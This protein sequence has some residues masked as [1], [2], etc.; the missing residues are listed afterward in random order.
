MGNWAALN[1]YKPNQLWSMQIKGTWPVELQESPKSALW[2]TEPSMMNNCKQRRDKHIKI[3]AWWHSVTHVYRLCQAWFH[4]SS[5][6]TLR[7]HANVPFPF[8]G[9]KRIMIICVFWFQKEVK[10]Y[11]LWLQ[12]RGIFVQMLMIL[13]YL[14]GFNERAVIRGNSGFCRTSNKTHRS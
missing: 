14:R 5:W 2:L 13:S 6:V 9:N 1:Q 8:Y 4:F 10:C 3:T 11:N 7:M 12:R